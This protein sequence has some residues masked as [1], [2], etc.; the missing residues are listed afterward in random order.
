MLLQKTNSLGKAE[1]KVD[2]STGRFSG[3]ASVFGGVDSYGDTIAKGAFTETLKT[4]GLPKMFWNHQWDMPIGKWLSA[5][6]DDR[7][8]W[9]DGELTPEL[10]LAKD[11]HA[12]LK[13]ATLDGLSI[14]GMLKRGDYEDQPGGRLIR[15]WT[16]LME[17]SPVVFPADGAARID[18]ASVKNETFAQALQAEIAELQTVREFETFL[19]EAGGF[20]KGAAAALVARVKDLFA[21][22]DAADES[23]ETKAMAQ[24]LER[25]KRLESLGL[26]A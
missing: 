6:E 11:V 10:T 12:A 4:H 22:R 1:L 18:S 13:H 7:G 23:G 15:R 9:V 24:L 14:G 19:R 8:L 2:Q 26:S 16:N 25:V 5:E 17:I 21:R 20:S 3:Y